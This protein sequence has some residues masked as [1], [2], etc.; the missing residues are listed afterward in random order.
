MYASKIVASLGLFLGLATATVNIGKDSAGDVS[1]Q[2]SP[3]YI[4]K[5]FLSDLPTSNGCLDQRR[6]RVQQ[7]L[8]RSQQWQPLQN[9]LH[10]QQRLHLPARWLRWYWPQLEQR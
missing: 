1:E 3:H 10:P 6:V 9:Q 4:L 8:H 5:T 2:F 7:H